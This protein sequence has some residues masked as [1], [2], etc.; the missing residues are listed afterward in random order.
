MT[1]SQEPSL[2]DY[3]RFHGIAIDH[4]AVIPLDQVPPPHSP[5]NDGFADPSDVPSIDPP[6]V[7]HS[8]EQELGSEKLEIPKD[9]ARFL[10]SLLRTASANPGGINRDSFFPEPHRNKN[11]KLEVP[12]LKRN[13]GP[14]SSLGCAERIALDPVK[15]QLPREN[16]S[17]E[18]DEGLVFP[19]RYF[20]LSDS[21]WKEVSTE[22]LDCSKDDLELLQ[23]IKGVEKPD[24][25]YILE[26][27][28][29]SQHGSNV[30]CY[31]IRSF[32]DSLTLCILLATMYEAPITRIPSSEDLS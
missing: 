15:L 20:D 6:V 22:K 19:K 31:Y 13:W 21:I 14:G 18:Q 23:R 27:V 26:K 7:H 25:G 29:E 32:L 4:Q 2:L 28:S 11:L 30:G 17:D 5:I 3:A 10:S 8:L 24:S 9:A 16:V 1:G 12:L